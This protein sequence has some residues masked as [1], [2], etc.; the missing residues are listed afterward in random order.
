MSRSSRSAIVTLLVLLGP[1]HALPGQEMALSFD[2]GLDHIILATGNLAQGTA[3]FARRT[4]VMP[5]FG[6][7]HPGRGTQNALASLGAGL[8]LELLAPISGK[9]DPGA[10]HLTPTGWAIH[11]RDLAALIRRV[12]AAGFSISGPLPGSRLTPDSTLLRWQTASVTGTRLELAPFFIEW[13][14]G[15]PHPSTTA[16]GGC[17]LIAFE[18]IA[19]DTTQ[20]HS[21]FAA[22][23]HHGTLS[24][25]TS[26]RLSVT[27]ACPRGTV[28]FTS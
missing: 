22:M 11:T 25:G 23:A 1:V 9:P 28:T 27:L 4:G 10:G 2:V 5:R 13:A 21:L 24:V 15:T 6:G 18:L 8:Y 19:P 7:Q 12:R 14:S 17:R 20:L 3:E 26:H 16:P